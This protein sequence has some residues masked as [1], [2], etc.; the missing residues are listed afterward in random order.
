M[1]GR[2]LRIINNRDFFLNELFWAVWVLIFNRSH[3][4]ENHLQFTRISVSEDTIFNTE[5]LLSGRY[6]VGILNADIYRYVTNPLSV[7]NDLTSD[8]GKNKKVINSYT[9]AFKSYD[10]LASSYKSD[11]PVYQRIKWL[12]TKNIPV[13]FIRIINTKLSISE[14]LTIK[15]DLV[16]SQA[17]PISADS[18]I[19]IRFEG[20]LLN[21]PLLLRLSS[22]IYRIYKRQI[23]CTD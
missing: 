3:I 15:Q 20:F 7:T 23:R 11:Q 4:L 18:E 22:V 1:G 6:N 19:I 8:N 2:D 9:E 13:I 16:K 12:V 10:I 17:I 21:H 14:L 5:Y